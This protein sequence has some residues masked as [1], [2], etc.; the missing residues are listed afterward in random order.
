V[1]NITEAEARSIECGLRIHAA[2]WQKLAGDRIMAADRFASPEDT[3]ILR[4]LTPVV[5]GQVRPIRDDQ[6]KSEKREPSGLADLTRPI[7]LPAHAESELEVF[8]KTAT[9]R[10]FVCMSQTQVP[11]YLSLKTA[12]DRR[13]RP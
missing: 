9:A 6:K 8:A 7:G 3:N 1:I 4:W 13:Y 10:D 12:R 5:E 11:V 2:N